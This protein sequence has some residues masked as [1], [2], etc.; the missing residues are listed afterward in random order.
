MRKGLGAALAALLIVIVALVLSERDAAAGFVMKSLLP[1][2]GGGYSVD[3]LHT[4]LSGHHFTL[5]DARVTRHGERVLTAK[6]IRISYN[7]RDLLPGSAH[8]FGLTA[9]AADGVHLTL[10]HHAD[11]TYN[12]GMP[13]PP[14]VAGPQIAYNPVPLAFSVNVRN[15]S[16]VLIDKTRYYR[17][18]GVQRVD[19]ISV[20]AVIDTQTVTHYVASGAL[21]DGGP[22]PFRLTGTIDEVRGYAVHHFTARSVPIATIGNYFINSPAAHISGGSIRDMR[23]RAWAFGFTP[24]TSPAYQYAGG[25]RL[26]NGDLQVH[27]LVSPIRHLAGNVVLFNGGF[28]APRLT[29][30]VGHIPIVAAGGIYDFAQPQFRLGVDGRADLRDLKDVAAFAAH[31]PIDGMASIHALIEGSV[32]QPLLLIGYRGKRFYYQAVPIDDPHG[33][34]ALYNGDLA[35]LPFEGYY[36]GIRMHVAGDLRLGPHVQSELVLNA[37]GP[38]T[39]IPYLGALVPPQPIETH[40]LLTGTDLEIDARGFIVAANDSR[41]VNGFYAIDHTGTGA[42]GPISIET[43][44]GGSLVAGF[45]LDRPHGNSGFWASLRNV[46]LRQPTP[47]TMPGIGIPQLPPMTAHIAEAG[48]AG[49]GSARNVVI[50]GSVSMH[51]AIISGV[52]FNAISARFAGP[53]AAARISDVHAD[54]PWGTFDGDGSFAPSAIVARGNYAGTLQGLHQ[55]LGSFPARGAISGPMAIAIAQGR[56]YIQAQNARLSRGAIHDIPLDAITGTMAYENGVLRVY[57]AQARTSGGTVV[58]AGTYGTTP[59]TANTRLAVATTPLQAA[60]LRH[61]FGLPLQGGRL[62]AVGAI[63]PGAALPRLDAGV[64]LTGGTAAGYGPFSA[65]ADIAIRGDALGVRHGVGGVGST[66]GRLHGSIGGLA[67]GTPRYRMDADIPAAG[68]RSVASAAHVSTHTVTGSAQARLQITGSGVDP[69]VR[70]TVRVPVGEINGMGFEDA[71]ARIAA[72]R[73]GAALRAGVVRVNSTVA[74]FNATVGKSQTAVSVRAPQAML[75]DFNDFFNTGDTL[76][77]TGSIG[78]SFSQRRRLVFTSGNVNIQGLRYRRLPIGNTNARWTSRRNVVHESLLV[79]GTHG[80]LQATGTIAFPL[81][82]NL[83]RLIT[84]SRYDV[85]AHLASLDLSTWLPALGFPQ[86]PMTGRVNAQA[87]VVGSYPQL[88]LTGT[89]SI[90]GGTLGPL[91]IRRADVTMRSAGDRLDVTRAVL[92][93]PALDATGSGSFGF[94]ATA[95]LQFTVHAVSNDLPRLIAQVSKK[96]LDLRGQIESTLSLGGT[97]A[98]PRVVAG[99]DATNLQAYGLTI[100]SFVGQV[101]LHRRNLVIRN[102]ELVFPKGQAYLAGSLPLQ[103]QPFGFGPPGAPIAM[104]IA[105][106]NIDLGAFQALLGN[107]TKLAGALSGHVGVSGSVRNPRIYGQV[108]VNGANYVS[109]LETVPITATAA[110]MTFNGTSAT[111][112]RLF[113]RVGGGILNGRGRLNF[114]GALGGSPVSYAL[115]IDTRGAQISLPQYGSGTFDSTLTLRRSG[116]KI[117]A[118]D[119]RVTV[120]DAIVPFAAFLKFGGAGGGPAGKPPLNL[121]F[122]LGITAGRNVR[123]RG[124]GVGIFGLDISGEGSAALRGTLL[125]PTLDGAFNSAGGTLTYIDHVFQVQTGA[126]TFTPA[127]GVIPTVYAVGTT[128]V[129]NP[130]PDVSRNPAGTADIT[131]TVSG[132]VTSPKIAFASNPAGYTEQQIIALLL[133]LGGLVGPI[134]FTDTGVLLGAGRLN[135][136]PAAGTGALLPSVLVRREN[137]ILTVGQE[138]FNILNAQFATGLL[139]PLESALGST[140]GTDVNLTFDYNGTFGINFRRLLAK[141]FYAIYGTTF[142]VPVRQTFGFAYQPNAAISAQFSMFVQ[143]GP[144]PLF[145]GPNQT[146][147]SNPR[148]AAGQAVQGTNGFT[149]LFQ[150][151]F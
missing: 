38:S 15:A 50:G 32:S 53:F 71:G 37:L 63:M 55:F 12:I 66:F 106:T 87:H 88:G 44:Q 94:A 121:A 8:R 101:L 130:D 81:T 61:G 125:N 69:F 90:L 139:A 26:T 83:R 22:Q 72:G 17:S 118:L 77:G 18:S 131:V 11:G 112:D 64:V 41:A 57:S 47:I 46:D 6:R 111:L 4:R 16:A 145:Q 105:A 65:S 82:A 96:H 42:F 92:S 99:I 30:E 91:P 70:G 51:P 59:G 128:H 124:G 75:S 119:G 97:L 140:I 109:A 2:A 146:L 13:A 113:A 138:A 123:V 137:G 39:R 149:F 144:V 141:D 102:A 132:P 86:V 5:V 49:A 35:V 89:A 133:P 21:V 56:I 33:A 108:A 58:A 23:A 54:G 151:L 14:G 79:G 68:I 29:A 84:Q 78:L 129:T 147:S 1:L 31:L 104:D 3:A 7:L 34:V 93:L 135:G 85:Q 126:V 24:A 103:L 143:Q 52:P 95:P 9:V 28:A 25:G 98:A 110:Q 43:P 134:Q 80:Q 40:A 36:D 48:L 127:N 136:A 73:S 10:V 74:T 115:A 27:A 148:A 117:A 20:R 67:E 114:G 142:G 116:G 45:D 19:D 122:N 120:S 60:A 107:R 76:A 100:P 150:R 62:T